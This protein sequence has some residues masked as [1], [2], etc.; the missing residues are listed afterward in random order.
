MGLRRYL[1][2]LL[3]ISN[4]LFAWGVSGHL[5]IAEI[6][7]QHLNK[8][9]RA[10]VDRL[11]AVFQQAYPQFKN[12]A[13]AASWADTLRNKGVTTFNHW[14][15]IDRPLRYT[16][17]VKQHHYVKHN[18]VWAILHSEQTLQNQQVTSLGKAEFLM[19]L[20]H[21]VGDA[22][23]P[24]HCVNFYS[25]R[26]PQGDRGGNLFLIKTSWAKNLHQ[27]WDQGGDFF[28]RYRK[29]NAVSMLG[30]KQLATKIQSDYPESYF[31]HKPKDLDP[32]DW[33]N[34][35]YHI[36]KTFAYHISYNSKPSADYQRQT[37]IISEQRIALAG[38]RLA[39]LLNQIL[40]AG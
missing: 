10:E 17:P 2:L 35:S 38:Y 1:L 14:H 39:N 30:I 6:A 19:F 12:F 16:Q 36:A 21:F 29:T 18:L 4:R 28:W 33:V 27:Y 31:A 8:Q 23:Q 15:F 24:L 22:H 32:N 34:E 3:L 13:E 7:Y 5:I 20:A 9:T 25:Q 26:F 11:S 37:Q 40:P